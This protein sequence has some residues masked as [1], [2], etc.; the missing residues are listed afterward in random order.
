MEKDT[1]VP[2]NFFS[3]ILSCDASNVTGIIDR[4][5]AQ[6]LITRREHPQDRR[7]KA[8][9]LTEKGNDLKEEIIEEIRAHESPA[10]RNLSEEQKQQLRVIA[11]LVLPE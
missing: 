9:V 10:F 5:S 4:L 6:N 3:T 7:I 8:V 1:P 2:M 11:S